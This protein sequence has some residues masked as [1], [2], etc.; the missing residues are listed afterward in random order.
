MKVLKYFVFWFVFQP[1]FAQEGEKSFRLG[2]G[3]GFGDEI[4]EKDYSLANQF[5]KV[6]L[7]RHVK[8]I[9]GFDFSVVLEP[10]INFSRHQ[11]LNL[12]FVEPHESNYEAL[13]NEFGKYKT[14]HQYVLNVGIKVEKAISKS[15]NIYLLG[16]V[17]SML[18]DT[19][20]E[21]LTK[22]FAFSDVIALGFSLISD[23]IHFDLRPSLRHVSNGGL[24]PSNAGLNSKNLEVVLTLPL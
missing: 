9:K 12:Y 15:F 3:F 23:G 14:M 6:H 17:G 7:Q 1:S 22:G 2:L 16:S 4:R 21:R 20:T 11:L 19:E 13:R 5:V 24:Q 10:E 8:K 18:T